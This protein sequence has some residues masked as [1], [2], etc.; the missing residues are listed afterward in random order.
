MPQN[1]QAID[2]IHRIVAVH[3]A[4]VVQTR[5]G[6]AKAGHGAQDLQ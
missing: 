2:R 4:G 3:V 5:G 1:A 6:R